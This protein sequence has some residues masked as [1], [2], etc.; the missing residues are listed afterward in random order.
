M[1]AGAVIVLFIIVAVVVRL[2]AGGFDHAR[3]RQYVESMGGT[4][5]AAYWAP[6]GPGWFGE[7]NDRIYEVH[8][9]DRD[10]NEH[11]AYCKTRLWA[12]VYFTQDQIVRYSDPSAERQ[13]TSLEEENQRLREEL[14]RLKGRQF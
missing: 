13:D 8:Y 3:V 1:E 4:F 7:K 14:A 5:L 12:S 9:L 10:G 11:H 2:T 6:F